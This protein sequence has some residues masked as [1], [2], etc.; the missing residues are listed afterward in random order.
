MPAK[1]RSVQEI[2]GRAMALKALFV[3]ASAPESAIDSDRVQ[4]Y[5]RRSDL[6]KYLTADERSILSLPRQK[7]L[8]EHAGTVGWRLENKWAL[9]WLLGYET[10]PDP[11]LGQ[12]PEDVTKGIMFDFLPNMD[13]SLNDLIAKAKLRPLNEVLQLEDTFYCSHNAVRSAQTGSKASVPPDFHPV[14]DG[15]AIHE[16]RHSLTWAVSDGVSWDD[17]DLST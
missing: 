13:S 1:L 9:C 10:P 17:T 15:G 16:R 5:V 14:R 6:T 7:A 3:W 12:L 8:G 11:T 2:A 4:K